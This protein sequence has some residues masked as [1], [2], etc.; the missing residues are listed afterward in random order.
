MRGVDFMVDVKMRELVW[1]RLAQLGLGR[2]I[3]V[4]PREWGEWEHDAQQRWG[5][6]SSAPPAPP[7]PA[8]HR[9][10]LAPPLVRA[11]DPRKFQHLMRVA[12]RFLEAC[13]RDGSA[14]R[15]PE[16][17]LTTVGACLHGRGLSVDARIGGSGLLLVGD[18]GA[19]GSSG[20]PWPWP[21]LAFGDAAALVSGDDDDDDGGEW[22]EDEDSREEVGGCDERA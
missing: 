2:S 11:G 14:P 22:S 12:G 3:G 4:A 16:I 19:D 9:R 6:P 7:P 8:I 18:V 17:M 21:D 15:R 1:A 5:G 13:A 20:L 10:A